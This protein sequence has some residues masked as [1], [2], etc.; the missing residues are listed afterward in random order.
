M[1]WSLTFYNNSQADYTVGF[2]KFF[3]QDGDQTKDPTD[4]G[5]TTYTPT[6]P[7]VDQGVPLPSGSTKQ[8]VITFSFVPYEGIPYTLISRLGAAYF[9]LDITF[10]PVV[11]QF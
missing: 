10:D 3:L 7:G 6:G 1:L 8:V 4:S 9:A 5:A 2:S 11:I